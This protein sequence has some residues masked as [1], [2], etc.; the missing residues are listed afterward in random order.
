MKKPLIFRKHVIEK[1]KLLCDILLLSILAIHA[2]ALLADTSRVEGN[3]APIK[4][5][6]VSVD[7]LTIIIPVESSELPPDPG[8]EGKA[9]VAGID[10]DN[11]GVRDDVE[12][13]IAYKYPDN[14]LTR[15]A[16]YQYSKYEQLNLINSHNKYKIK[17]YSPLI[18]K[19]ISCLYK[20][21]EKEDDA[22]AILKDIRVIIL[23]THERFRANLSVNKHL[24]GEI[25][26]IVEG[27]ITT[28]CE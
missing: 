2:S 28:V 23:N 26:Y 24:D 20:V 18:N 14:P 8:E 1:S 11:D 3:E 12:R 6:P 19:A 27:T 25:G 9:D 22:H 10:S 5:I 16:L 21:R 13:Y 7:D 17:G 15:K 4:H